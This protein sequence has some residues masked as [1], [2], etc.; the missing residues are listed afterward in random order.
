MTYTSVP[1]LMQNYAH[2]EG[3]M[4]LWVGSTASFDSWYPALSF[5]LTI[6]GVPASGGICLQIYLNGVFVGLEFE[7]TTAT[8]YLCDEQRHSVSFSAVANEFY[9]DAWSW[10]G[11]LFLKSNSDRVYD[12]MAEIIPPAIPVTRSFLWVGRFRLCKVN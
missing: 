9:N 12:P 2:D 6:D 5:N 1:L 8:L 3:E 7:W 10:T 11:T 4:I